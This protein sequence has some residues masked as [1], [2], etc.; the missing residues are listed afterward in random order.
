V[1]STAV[2]VQVASNASQS[3]K[4]IVDGMVI[5]VR[6]GASQACH[7]MRVNRESDSNEIDESD[8]QD[9]KQ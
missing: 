2:S 6:R 9:E 8:L 1:Q 5:E 7:S 4:E 3:M